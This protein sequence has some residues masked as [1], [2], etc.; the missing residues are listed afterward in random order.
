M[1]PVGKVTATK[2]GNDM[3]FT[4]E[5]GASYTLPGYAVES[6]M[7]HEIDSRIDL[8]QPIY[9]QVAKLALRD[10]AAKRKRSVAAA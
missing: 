5:S 10:K 6:A 8:T 2:V 1:E 9:D 4:D 3:V 7:P